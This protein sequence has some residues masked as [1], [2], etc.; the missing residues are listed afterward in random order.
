MQGIR[1]AIAVGQLT[2]K[3]SQQHIG[4]WLDCYV[5]PLGLEALPELAPTPPGAVEAGPTLRP[6]GPA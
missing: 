1:W 4:Y 5:A 3:E 6:A 2:M